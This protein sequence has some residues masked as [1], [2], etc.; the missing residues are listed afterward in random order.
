MKAS[1]D[2]DQRRLA[3]AVLAEEAVHFAR[4]T[5][6]DTPSSARAPPKVLR[7]FGDP[8]HRERSARPGGQ[9]SAGGFAVDPV[10]DGAPY[11]QLPELVEAG[12]VGVAIALVITRP[13]SRLRLAL[14]L[15][16]I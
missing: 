15:S 7:M 8:K 10:D 16:K 1:E 4:P 11:L 14:L 5:S 2:L 13:A 3:R 12:Y 9:A 6:S